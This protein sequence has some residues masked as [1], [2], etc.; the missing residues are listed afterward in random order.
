MCNWT[1]KEDDLEDG[2]NGQYQL[3]HTLIMEFSKEFEQFQCL[4]IPK[5]FSRVIFF[6]LDIYNRI[7]L[8]M[9]LQPIKVGFSMKILEMLT[10]K[11]CS[12]N[13]ET[14]YKLI[15]LKNLY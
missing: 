4:C 1:F 3:M 10:I 13:C 5:S 11:E 15:G 12:Q 7:K 2:I 8:S 9:F 14:I 6:Y